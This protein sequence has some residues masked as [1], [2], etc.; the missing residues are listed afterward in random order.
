V[1]GYFV[2]LFR[3]LTRDRLYT[4]I[5][6]GGLALGLASC[7]VL[8]L[9]LWSE[10]TYDRHYQGHE[11][12]Y[13]VENEFTTSGK[14]EKLA[15]TSDGLGPTIAAE[16]PDR[17]A[18][19]V[20]MRDNT[21]DGGISMRRVDQPETVYY[22][23]N[24]FFVDQNIFDVLPIKVISGDPKTA[25]VD[26]DTIAISETVARKHFGAENPIGKTMMSDSGSANRITLVFADLPPNTHLKYD[27]L[28]SFNRAFL[29]LNDNPTMRRAQLSGPQAQT[30]TFLR[31]HPSFRPSEWARMSSDFDAKYMAEVLKTANIT[32]R[33]WLQPIADVHL[34]SEVG[35][36]RPTGN[37]AYLFGCA[38]VALIILA[39]ACINYMNLATARATRR[40]RSV[41]FRKILGA[42]RTSLA[43][44]FLGE[45]LF[46]SLI[47]LLLAVLL[48]AAV[49]KFTPINALMDGK[50]GLE[51]LQQP[52][53]ALSLLAAALGVGLLSGIYPAFY[54]S[55][56][57]PLTALTGKQQSLGKGNLHLREF[58]V[59]VQFTISAAAIAVTLLMMA[60][61]SYVANQ[62]LGF[63][64]DNRLMVSLRGAAT[65][66]KIPAIRNALLADARIKGVAVA[67]QTPGDSPGIGMVQLENAEGA[68]ERQ[69][70]TVLNIGDDYEKVLG[71]TV[72]EGRDLSSRLITDVGSNIMVNETLVK[73]MGWDNA[74]GK[75]V[76]DGRVVGVMKD[77]NFRSLKFRIEPLV[78]RK[79]SNDMSRVDEINKPFQQRKLILDVT[80][81][82]VGPLLE[83]VGRVVADADPRH[84]FEYRFLDE[85]LKKQYKAETS[86][87]RLIGIFAAVSI[88]I[89]CM[90]L[91]GLAAF[92]T[93]QRS[94]E[95]GTRKVL[96]A[97]SWQI[98]MLLAKR[99][100]VLVVVA[101]V[102]A[103][104]GAYFAIDE[105]LAGFA[106]RA[107][108][109]PL[110]FLLAAAVAAAVAF[111]TVALQ[112]WKTASADPVQ[113]LRQV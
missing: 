30:Y 76:L 103:S 43:L 24:S 112:S 53:V 104:I 65:V 85:A 99:I 109:N 61:M 31:M 29:K 67:A 88:L 69:L 55:S 62:P 16:Y 107:G 46:F 50:V 91:F 23:E 45:S 41:G 66:E 98:I 110:I 6:I 10:L 84:P 75:R 60:Q 57:A 17:I 7:L 42:S 73:K 11:N 94:R 32:W 89:A 1:R 9:F 14:T 19:Y 39:I 21:N 72:A 71:L 27:L 92:T 59:L 28:W 4:A 18:A 5:N 106:Y 13:R 2:V 108:V 12:I 86:L 48:V 52:A 49:L 44:Q 87:T 58:L 105:W 78:I 34:Y 36:D 20:R 82:E 54:L 96:G 37:R 15:I 25:L 63:E 100:L 93:E 22:W 90:G 113:S 64:R 83:F 102:L 56:W 26:G 51:M 47:A 40:A 3:N 38:A 80:G 97:T 111:T 79:L 8:G 68:Q 33:S 70:F 74:I 77:F 81:A 95:I 101:A 35:Y